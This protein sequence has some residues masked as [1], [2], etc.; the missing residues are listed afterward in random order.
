MIKTTLGKFPTQ[1]ILVPLERVTRAFMSPPPLPFGKWTEATEH[2]DLEQ[3]LLEK[4]L[5]QASQMNE[6]HPLAQLFWIH[7][8]I[9]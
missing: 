1:W 4:P 2:P 8:G 6:K 5:R 9:I 7:L 3:L